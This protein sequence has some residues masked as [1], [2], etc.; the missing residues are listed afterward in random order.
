[1]RAWT[2]TVA[3]LLL[4]AGPLEA[5]P[6]PGGAWAEAIGTPLRVAGDLVGAAGLGAA[7]VTGVGGDAVALVDAT[8]IPPGPLGGWVSGPLHRAAMAVSHAATACLEALRD[9]D[10]ERFPEARAAYLS[11]APGRGRLDTFLS[12]AGALR[13]AV[14]EAVTGPSLALL[15][16]LGAEEQAAALARSRDE[17]RDRLLGPLPPRSIEP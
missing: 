8:W 14:R 12:G 9:E 2:G 10:I 16:L 4:G 3:F 13:L 1:M 17:A 15:R 11:A 5:A 6:D 7:A